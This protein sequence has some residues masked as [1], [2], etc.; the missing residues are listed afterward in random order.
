MWAIIEKLRILA[1]AVTKRLLN[2]GGLNNENKCCQIESI[3]YL[4]ILRISQYANTVVISKEIIDS[5]VKAHG[6][7]HYLLTQLVID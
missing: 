5:K 1:N 2:N 6:A 3:Q 4:L 7:Y